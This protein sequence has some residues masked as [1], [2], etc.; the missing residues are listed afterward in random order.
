LCNSKSTLAVAAVVAAEAAEEEVAVLA[1]AE[2]A[3]DSRR[4]LDAL[5]VRRPGQVAA[6]DQVRQRLERGRVR[7]RAALD[8][9]RR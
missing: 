4:R 8:R 1:R 2:A 9:A 7:H 5:L 3:A 6:R